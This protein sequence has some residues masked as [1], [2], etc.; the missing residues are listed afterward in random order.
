MTDLEQLK[1]DIITEDIFFTYND[2]QCSASLEVDDSIPT[3]YMH[4][5]D[6]VRKEYGDFDE[7]VQDKIFDGKSLSEILGVV[8]IR[9][10]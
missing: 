5:G 7:M 2:E 6:I 4:Y 3:Y 10:H 1:E 8:K 9:F